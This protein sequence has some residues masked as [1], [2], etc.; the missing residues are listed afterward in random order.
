MR[1]I[2]ALSAALLVVMPAVA[3]NPIAVS[4]TFRTNDPI[5]TVVSPTYMMMSRNDRMYTKEDGKHGSLEALGIY[6]RTT[7]H[8]I[9]DYFLPVSGKST[10]VA[11]EINSAAANTVP[12]TVD[13]QANYFNVQT[14]GVSTTGDLANLTFQSNLTFDPRQTMA[15]VAFKWQQGFTVRN[16]DLYFKVSVPVIQVTND[17]R[18]SEEVIHTGGIG[19]STPVVPTGAVANMTEAFKQPLLQYGRID[20]KQSKW[21]VADI[22]VILGVDWTKQDHCQLSTFIGLVAPTGNRPKA[23]YL[24][25]AIVGNN[26]HWGVLLGGSSRH[27]WKEGDNYTLTFLCDGD[28]RYLFENT[29]TRMFD[30]VDKPWG[31]YIYLAD[32]TVTAALTGTDSLFAQP[33]ANDSLVL[34]ANFLTQEVQVKP[35]G[36]FMINTA[37]NYRHDNGCELEGG[38]NFYTRQAEKVRLKNDFANPNSYGIPL[39]SSDVGAG[40]WAQTAS[41]A[42]IDNTQAG[43][44]GDINQISGANIAVLITEADLDFNSASHPA[45]LESSFYGIAGKNWDSWRFPCYAGVGGSYTYSVDNSGT[46]RW[47][48]FGKLGVSF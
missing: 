13:I 15:G 25:E 32:T 34:G 1:R 46:D 23:E 26:H 37:L 36:A 30:L 31:R 20:G 9:R 40:N 24:Y 4:K 21:G 3:E 48:V 6:S 19:G 44:D 10:L 38:F 8:G 14:H 16:R 47:A 41:F 45:V 39:L 35:Y 2:S 43:G 29:Q 42:T 12:S 7:G 27:L 28:W 17:L 5:F 33:T 22:E 18:F 11:G